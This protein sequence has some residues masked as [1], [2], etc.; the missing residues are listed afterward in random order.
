MATETRKPEQAQVGDP[1]A[2][3]DEALSTVATEVKEAEMKPK[4]RRK[5]EKTE[6]VKAAAERSQTFN[7]LAKEGTYEQLQSITFEAFVAAAARE[8]GKELPPDLEKKLSDIAGIKER[9]AKYNALVEAVKNEPRMKAAADALRQNGEV[10]MKELAGLLHEWFKEL[11][12]RSQFELNTADTEIRAILD[13]SVFT[14]ETEFKKED[15]ESYKERATAALVGQT[16]IEARKKSEYNFIHAH[17]NRQHYSFFEDIKLKQHPDK[18]IVNDTLR[19]QVKGYVAELTA[20]QR[21]P[22]GASGEELRNL[23]KKYFGEQHSGDLQRQFL[24]Y[25]YNRCKDK[26]FDPFI[27]EARAMD[28]AIEETET[29]TTAVEAFA[30]E[31]LRNITDIIEQEL[32]TEEERRKALE[33]LKIQLPKWQV[34]AKMTRSK[35]EFHGAYAMFP[36]VDNTNATLPKWQA[37]ALKEYNE[38]ALFQR[39]VLPHNNMIGGNLITDQMLRA[40]LGEPAFGGR[41][42]TEESPTTG[43][44][45]IRLRKD[46]VEKPKITSWR[47]IDDLPV[48]TLNPELVAKATATSELIEKTGGYSYKKKEDLQLLRVVLARS[49]KDAPFNAGTGMH[50]GDGEPR[51]Y[52][53]GQKQMMRDWQEE[54]DTRKS[55]RKPTTRE[56]VDRIITE[57]QGVYPIATVSEAVRLVDA[58]KAEVVVALKMAEE[59]KRVGEQ[60]KAAGQQE[61]LAAQGLVKDLRGQVDE[62]TR[63]RDSQK[64]EAGR[65]RQRAE[66]AETDTKNVKGELS[67][68]NREVRNLK[69]ALEE[70]VAVIDQG[71]A[72]AAEIGGLIGVEGKKR[73]ALEKILASVKE[74]LLGLA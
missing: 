30:E 6:V 51:F 15:Y 37:A 48:L 46:F 71:T 25:M 13:S 23:Y 68:K 27:N 4:R 33:Y 64:D 36:N 69:K 44:G 42:V 29:V 67:E 73:A 70:L 20:L 17:E 18:Q 53:P 65:Q 8:L 7:K 41:T 14:A 26:G 31:K 62:V 2:A 54:I 59:G 38:I 21:N 35:E 43:E 34:D 11:G 61:A 3:F 52:D 22:E 66:K 57:N 1:L 10:V 55:T 47:E 39:M 60:G 58:L 49:S 32:P 74:K 50:G 12:E 56:E 16:V 9:L 28:S 63:A 72:S 45:I 24:P 19:A 5:E 40:E